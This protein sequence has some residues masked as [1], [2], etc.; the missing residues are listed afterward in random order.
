MH[1]QLAESS[2]DL[3]E[4]HIT[5]ADKTM[6]NRQD[7]GQFNPG[8][9]PA[10]IFSPAHSEIFRKVGRGC[11]SLNNSWGLCW[12]L[13]QCMG[14]LGCQGCVRTPAVAEPALAQK[15]RVADMPQL[16]ATAILGQR[17]HS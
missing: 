17:F 16:Y 12:G 14:G 7:P 5:G 6:Q 11:T 9:F 10:I 8:Y 13:N 1:F 4:M 2:G 3:F 15:A